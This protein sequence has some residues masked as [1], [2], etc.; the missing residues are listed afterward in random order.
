MG[1]DHGDEG[2]VHGSVDRGHG[3]VDVAAN[4]LRGPIEI[5]HRLIALDADVDLQVDRLIAESIVVHPVVAAVLAIG[6]SLQA[7]ADAAFGIV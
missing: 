6:K 2:V 7:F 5:D 4:L 1:I 3:T